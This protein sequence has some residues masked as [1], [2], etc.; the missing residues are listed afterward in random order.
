MAQGLADSIRRF[1]KGADSTSM[2][3]SWKHTRNQPDTRL[4]RTL[5]WGRNSG[6]WL[7]SSGLTEGMVRLFHGGTEKEETWG[8]QEGDPF[9][10]I[11]SVKF[12]MEPHP[13]MQVS[14]IVFLVVLQELHFHQ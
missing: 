12:T 1:Q 5:I 11:S 4:V 3:C 9:H 7:L 14:G 10:F 13:P 8:S 6:Q 2:N